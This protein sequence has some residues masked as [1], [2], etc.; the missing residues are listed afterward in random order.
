MR[1]TTRYA[2]YYLATEKT[3]MPSTIRRLPNISQPRAAMRRVKTLLDEILTL[4]NSPFKP[5][6]ESWV[7]LAQWGSVGHMSKTVVTP[8]DP[9]AQNMR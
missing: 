8:R 3:T 7:S 1:V 4:H 6:P 5:R 2:L 9:S